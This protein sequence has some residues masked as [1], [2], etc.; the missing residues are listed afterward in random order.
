MKVIWLWQTWNKDPLPPLKSMRLKLCQF[1]TLDKSW[2]NEPWPPSLKIWNFGI[3]SVLESETNVGTRETPPPPPQKYWTSGLCQFRTQEHQL[4]QGPVRPPWDDFETPFG[5]ASFWTNFYLDDL[6]GNLNCQCTVICTFI[7]IS[8]T[9][10]RRHPL[11]R[12]FKD[13]NVIG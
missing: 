5:G 10:S 12:L 2:S 7:I 1:W 11:R 6:I 4:E 13:D 8:E 3:V 9:G